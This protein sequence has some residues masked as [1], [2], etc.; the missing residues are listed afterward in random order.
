M[1]DTF[2]IATNNAGKL[3]EISDI[4]K[5]LGA[6]AISQ[7]QAGIS[8]EPEETGKTFTE[9]ALIKARAAC[10][11]SG[12][13]AI[14]D[15]SGLCVDALNGA[16]GIYSA[17]FCEKDHALFLLSK[18]KGEENRRAHFES[19][20]ACVFP[21]GEE[22]TACGRC[23]GIITDKPRGTEGFGYDPVFLDEKSGKTFAELSEEEKN[24]I[25]HR[26]RALSRL[27]ELI[28]EKRYADK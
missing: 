28:K 7:K 25:S 11:A 8:S 24:K 14:A 13:P 1:K 6:Q 19:A 21:D 17:R 20:A 10:K 18:M 15:D 2:V 22:I 26:G 4:L 5:K 3:R 23:D 12:L 27:A 9:N 16:P